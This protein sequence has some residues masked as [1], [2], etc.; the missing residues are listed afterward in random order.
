MA[1]PPWL[2][3]P[4]QIIHSDTLTLDAPVVNTNT[5]LKAL[6]EWYRMNGSK[7]IDSRYS[8][9]TDEGR[10]NQLALRMRFVN[11]QEYPWLACYT[12][13]G[14]AKEKVYVFLLCQNGPAVLEDDY[15]MFP[16]DT[17]ITQLRLI[18]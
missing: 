13:V 16:S 14:P 3:P 2:Q 5:E 1:T 17:L 6:A 9:D 12:A 10:R 18:G 4:S 11:G 15:E 8:M 7:G